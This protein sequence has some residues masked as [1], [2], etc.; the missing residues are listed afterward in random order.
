MIKSIIITQLVSGT[1]LLLVYMFLYRNSHRYVYNRLV[2]LSSLIISVVLPFISFNVIP[3]EV[4]IL[5]NTQTSKSNL[6]STEV[7][8]T[9]SI[10]TL[11]VYIYWIGVIVMGFLFL[12]NLISI[13]VSARK[14]SRIKDGDFTLFIGDFAS[15]SF[16][17]NIFLSEQDPIVAMH[18]KG[19]ATYLHSIDRMVVALIT[20]F[21]WYNPCIYFYRKLIIENH[22]YQ[23][24]DFAIKQLQLSNSNYAEVLL[25]QAKQSIYPL[26]ISNQ[27]NS[28]IKNRLTMLVN[29]SSIR[30]S[31]YLLM[32][33]TFLGLFSAFT[34]KTY[35]V[36]ISE[37]SDTSDTIPGNILLVDTIIIFDYE[38][39]SE[40][41]KVVKSERLANSYLATMVLSGEKTILI[42]TVYIFDTNTKKETLEE[43]IYTFPKEFAPFYDEMSSV[44]RSAMVEQ[45]G[46]LTRKNLDPKK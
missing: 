23:A 32:I 12:K 8:E 39:N 16:F 41:I 1:I 9:F 17:Y 26:S 35:P 6:A 31:V 11:L 38:T 5:N 33:P 18:E 25:A 15:S 10:D 3:K 37:N 14:G 45:Y 27:F 19:H 7:I 13:V 44:Q 2:L 29:Q 20:I 21:N 46:K 43:F 40:N 34:F 22:E 24:D 36:Y 28:S 30:K 42:D 4:L